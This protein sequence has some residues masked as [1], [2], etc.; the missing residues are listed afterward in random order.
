MKFN[1]TSTSIIYLSCIY[2]QMIYFCS[3]WIIQL[4]IESSNYVSV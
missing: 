3:T 1:G 2:L 4:I